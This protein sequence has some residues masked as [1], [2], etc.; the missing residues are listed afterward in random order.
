MVV[1]WVIAIASIVAGVG[2]LG[3]KRWSRTLAIAVSVVG[4]LS[5]LLSFFMTSSIAAE[6]ESAL[7]VP[8]EGGGALAGGLVGLILN[9]A[10]YGFVL[11]VLWRSGDYLTA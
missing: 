4:I 2:I 6:I 10:V 8:G 7:G 11:W 3:G 1:G 5:G 9:L